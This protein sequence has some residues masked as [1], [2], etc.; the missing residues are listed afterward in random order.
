MDQQLQQDEEPT[1]FSKYKILHEDDY[2]ALFDQFKFDTFYAT[3]LHPSSS[4]S[5]V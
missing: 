2:I 5:S 1:H 4:V 3:I